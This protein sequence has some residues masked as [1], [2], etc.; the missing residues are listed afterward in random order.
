MWS[1]RSDPQ[2]CTVQSFYVF[3]D[4]NSNEGRSCA[5]QGSAPAFN[6][7]GNPLLPPPG[8]VQPGGNLGGPLD[9]AIG[10]D[11]LIGQGDQARLMASVSNSPGGL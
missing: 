3:V 11:Y 5:V 9:S 8:A 6:N 7:V 1:S 4:G 10:P 2:L